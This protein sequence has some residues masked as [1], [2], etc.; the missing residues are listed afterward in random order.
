MCR[1]HFL[2]YLQRFELVHCGR[3]LCVHCTCTVRALLKSCTRAQLDGNLVLRRATVPRNHPRTAI[4]HAHVHTK[5]IFYI[6]IYVYAYRCTRIYKYVILKY[7]SRFFNICV[8]VSRQID[9][10][11]THT[12]CRSKLK[13]LSFLHTPS[14]NWVTSQTFLQSF[15]SLG[16]FH[17]LSILAVLSDCMHQAGFGRE[18]ER[19]NFKVR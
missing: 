13:K 8:Y 1:G 5:Y 4:F 19:S 7:M 6:Y 16:Q 15:Q 3:A 11:P 17:W 14:A 10:F 9:L 12:C 18:T 2:W